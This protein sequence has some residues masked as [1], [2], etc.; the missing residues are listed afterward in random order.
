MAPKVSVIN[1]LFIIDV[2]LH[3]FFA[4]GLIVALRADISYRGDVFFIVFDHFG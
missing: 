1:E 3:N 2:F 4:I